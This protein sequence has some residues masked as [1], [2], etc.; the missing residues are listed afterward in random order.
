MRMPLKNASGSQISE[1]MLFQKLSR[2][3]RR[4]MNASMRSMM[5]LGWLPSRSARGRRAGTIVSA[6][7]PGSDSASPPV[8][9]SFSVAGGRR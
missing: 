1:Q 9:V 8:P 3:D 2:T 4:L 7:V 5:F 6:G